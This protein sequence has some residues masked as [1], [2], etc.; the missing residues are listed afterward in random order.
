MDLNAIIARFMDEKGNIALPPNFTIPALTEMLYGAH[1]QAGQADAVSIR[2]WDY[3]NSAEGETV[4][5]TRRQ[6][7]TRIKAIAARLMQV[8]EPGDRVAILA[9]NSPEYILGFMAGMYAGQVP[10]PLYDPNEP[11]HEDHL[12]AVLYDSGAKTVLTN[13]RGAPA[14][15]AYFADMPSAERPRVIAVDA[16]PDTL[17]KDWAPLQAEPGTDTSQD[18]AFL[19]YTSGSTRTP[20]GVE[21][22]SESIVSNVIQIYSG[23]GVQQPMRL[24]SWLPLHHD[25]G[26]VVSTLLII[27]GNE[28]EIFTP[29][30]FVQQPKR[31]MERL[32]RRSHDP[33]DMH[34]Y[35]VAPNF[36]LDMAARY[37]APGTNGAP[38]YDFS[39]L[40]C[41]IIGS[42]P[43]T[44]PG[45]DA[46]FDAFGGAGLRREV[47]RPSYGLA[48]ATLLVSTPQAGKSAEIPR[49]E[50]FDREQLAAGTATKVADSEGVQFASN[51]QP[52]SWMHFAI[53][54]P[55]TK[56][57]VG[58]NSV[59]EIWVHG[60]NVAGGYLERKEETADTF[61]NTIGAT[62]QEGL[63]KDGWLN[64]GDL[65]VLVDGELFITG[66]VKDLV[67]V[68]GRNHYPQDIE[69]TVMDASEQ[70]RK[71]SVAA[72]SVPGDDVERLVILVERGDTADPAGD[73]AA[74]D[75]IRAAVSSNHG[76]S[77][78]VV[79]FYAPNEIA[80]SSS[81]KIARRVN[82]KRFQERANEN[83]Q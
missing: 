14:V 65:G 79:E 30:E 44:K 60:P 70:V 74:E 16:L 72:F 2:Y 34:I 55:E 49:F 80:R 56:D 19:Q 73:A 21:L 40:E 67:V 68:A 77:P 37:A 25:M 10:I 22:T 24:V 58:Q 23:V 61:A 31:W 3:S 57:E 13:K 1:A 53:V 51:G 15:R 29:Q 47:L 11:G 33:E 7:N 36:A 26:I 48:E 82:A 69:A 41:I 64:T 4:E 62:I 32:S 28:M 46:F 76:V 59:G 78:D 6:V 8:G 71:D 12:R 83:T 18:T 27:L 50:V 9:G 17:A 38:D 75:A 43:V 54:D 45:V 5:Y 35:T 39:Q 42:E 66:R 52:V 63:P 20:A 81:G